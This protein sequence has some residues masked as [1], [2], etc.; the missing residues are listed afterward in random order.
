MWPI[1]IQY[2]V[3]MSSAQIAA[4]DLGERTGPSHDSW[5]GVL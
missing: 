4:L 2:S 3:G 1:F 5:G